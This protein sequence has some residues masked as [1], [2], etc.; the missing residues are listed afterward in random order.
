MTATISP[1]HSATTTARRASVSTP[2]GT[3]TVIADDADRVLASGWTED[4]DYLID[5]VHRSI[6][7]VAVLH[8][9]RRAR[10]FERAVRRVR[11]LEVRAGRAQH[12]QRRAVLLIPVVR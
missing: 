8:T 11:L 10:L 5:L 4:A 2:D 12:L 1:T 9:A 6:R 3:F 7:P